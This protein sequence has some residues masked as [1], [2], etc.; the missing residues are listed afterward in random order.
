MRLHQVK[1]I[2]GFVGTAILFCMP[3]TASALPDGDR[4][5]E[6][7]HSAG[8]V[9]VGGGGGGEIPTPFEEGHHTRFE[10]ADGETYLLRGFIQ[11]L[12]SFEDSNKGPEV[13]FKP[14]FYH[15]PWLKSRAR[16]A[17]PFYPM[18]AT[19]S[20]WQNEDGREV[21]LV[22]RAHGKVIDL[23]DGPVYVISLE[24]LCQF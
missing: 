13:Y 3:L 7:W 17:N 4:C 5:H 19:R 18:D 6:L 23:G 9:C 10:L 12:S 20:N 8:K 16:L 24:P 15:M 11:I 14:N 1:A 2:R 21:I 22:A